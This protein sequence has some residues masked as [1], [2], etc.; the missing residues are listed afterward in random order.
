M[1][2][3]IKNRIWKNLSVVLAASLI[4][5]TMSF[6]CYGD[7]NPL[8]AIRGKREVSTEYE[9][10]RS[11]NGG[12]LPDMYDLGKNGKPT[13]INGRLSEGKVENEEDA[14][15]VIAGISSII[16]ISN[17]KDFLA[18][19]YKHTIDFKGLNDAAE[20]TTFY[21]F[22]QYID[23][24]IVEDGCLILAVGSDG[25]AKALGGHYFQEEAL[26]KKLPQNG[27]VGSRED[28]ELVLKNCNGEIFLTRKTTQDG[29]EVY[30]DAY[31]GEVLMR[32]PIARG[33]AA[34]GTGAGLDGVSVNFPV[35][36]VEYEGGGYYLLYDSGDTGVRMYNAFIDST[37]P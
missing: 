32:I 34:T 8:G 15:A 19:N 30:T 18:L 11:L 21:R 9:M 17:V 27:V 22:Q 3:K 26:R 31:T 13:F 2:S 24:V 1:T 28:G 14:R 23:G 37:T 29:F 36:K 6:A 4:T 5:G 35:E 12:A 10:L 33:I 20:A 25:Y 7:E 16:G